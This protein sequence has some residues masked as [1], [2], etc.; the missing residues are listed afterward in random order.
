MPVDF[1]VGLEGTGVF[2]RLWSVWVV[3]ELAYYT[4]TSRTCGKFVC[5][6]VV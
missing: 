1:W 6:A 4:V 5:I 2:I 3:K